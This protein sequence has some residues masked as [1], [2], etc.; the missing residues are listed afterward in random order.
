LNRNV[1]LVFINF[2]LSLNLFQLQPTSQVYPVDVCCGLAYNT[3]ELEILFE[4][5]EEDQK[6]Y[7]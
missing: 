5:T 3:I 6:I 7:R 4:A 2:S 1:V